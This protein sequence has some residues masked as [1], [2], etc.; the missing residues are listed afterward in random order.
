MIFTSNQIS[1]MFIVEVLNKALKKRDK[2]CP[3]TI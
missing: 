1:N 2:D 3:A